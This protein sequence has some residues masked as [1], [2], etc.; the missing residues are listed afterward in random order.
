MLHVHGFKLFSELIY[1][2][3]Y[4][5]KTQIQ[6]EYLIFLIKTKIKQYLDSIIFCVLKIKKKSTE[7]MP[8]SRRMTKKKKNWLENF[9]LFSFEITRFF[10]LDKSF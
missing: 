7:T 3:L 5:M 4:R 6:I 1:L 9:L 8:F 10:Q 2:R